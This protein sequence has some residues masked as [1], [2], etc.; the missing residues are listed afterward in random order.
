MQHFF[1]LVSLLKMLCVG[2]ENGRMQQFPSFLCKCL[3]GQ[4]TKEIAADKEV[5]LVSYLMLPR[6][7]QR[8]DFVVPRPPPASV[9]PACSHGTMVYIL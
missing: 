9:V 4:R 1:L 6:T 2:M 3:L 7:A 8:S 5:F